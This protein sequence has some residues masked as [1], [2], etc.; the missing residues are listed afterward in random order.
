MRMRFTQSRGRD[1]DELCFRVQRS[2]VTYPAIPHSAPQPTDH[3]EDDVG[4][5]A[6]VGDSPLY[7]LRDELLQ[8]DLTLLEIAVGRAL[9]H[10]GQAAH[11][12]N[13]LEAP[14]LQR[15]DSPGLSSVPASID[16]IITLSAPAASAFTASPEYLMPP[17]AMTGMSPAPRTASTIAVICGTPIPVTTRVVQIDPGPTPTLIASTPRSARSRAPDS[18]ATFPATSCASGK[19]SRKQA[20]ASSTPWLCPWAESTT[21]TSQPASSS[22]WARARTSGVPPTA[23]ATRSRPC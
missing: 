9:F 15:N 19:A 12:A 7:P 14:A 10:G 23:A 17:S 4:N 11:A 5:R 1:P 6:A 13:H 18:V 21:I 3:L 2:D 20:T 16:P 8:R 22:A